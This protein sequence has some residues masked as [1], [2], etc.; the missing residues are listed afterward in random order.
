MFKIGDIVRLKNYEK[1]EL[2]KFKITKI[3]E[4]DSSFDEEYYLIPIAMFDFVLKS[5]K[6]GTFSIDNVIISSVRWFED[7]LE[8]FKY[9]EPKLKYSL[10]NANNLTIKLS[11]T[12]SLNYIKMPETMK[13]NY[14]YVGTDNYE[15]KEEKDYM[16]ILDIYGER[17]EKAIDDEFAR[18]KEEIIAEDEVQKII[19]EMQKQ[20]NTILEN[21][22]SEDR[23][24]LTSPNKN[25]LTIKS[26][27]KIYEL[28]K[29]H[30]KKY[31]EISRTIEEVKALF[32]L[33]ED[34]TERIKI[35]EKYGIMKNGKIN[36]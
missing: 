17:K 11:P 35:L 33:T 18:L 9:D 2:N 31:A 10:N 22:E 25:I 36:G 1:T 4:S 5:R 34:Y 26:Q 21:D 16:K 15:K 12:D 6:E 27:E 14:N 13:M 19:S 30:K 7:D 3:Q 23:I 20:I 32:E 8:L 28:E 24:D 29:E